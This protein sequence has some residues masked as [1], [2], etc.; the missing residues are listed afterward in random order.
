[1]SR[2]VKLGIE[3]VSSVPN[4]QPGTAGF[5]DARSRPVLLSSCCSCHTDSE[6]GVRVDSRVELIEGGK[7]SLLIRTFACQDAKPN[8][9][10]GNWLTDVAGSVVR[11]IMV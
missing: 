1:M 3:C 8:V 6:V 7:P 2:T 4:V 9:G 11:E 5:F 10:Q